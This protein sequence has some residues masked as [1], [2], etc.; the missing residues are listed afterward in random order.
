MSTTDRPARQM[1]TVRNFTAI[2]AGSMKGFCDVQLVSGMVLHR[3]T[4]FA[5]DGKAWAG[6]PSKQVIGR[7]GTVQR[8]P[9]G[10]ARYEPTVS[11]ADR[12]TADRWSAAVIE[13]VRQA[14]PEALD[15]P[16]SARADTPQDRPAE[17]DRPTRD[18]ASRR[19][20]RAQIA[21][22]PIPF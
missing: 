22:D 17:R 6:A 15:G 10:K 9:D 3:C 7:D 18:H 21:D 20:P 11:F 8:A 12:A 13:A 19:G 1:M 16:Q 5:K 2:S 14:F 4:I